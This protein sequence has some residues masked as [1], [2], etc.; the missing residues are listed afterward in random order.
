MLLP[1]D[2]PVYPVGR[3]GAMAGVGV[4]VGGTAQVS[5]YKVWP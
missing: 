4:G 1:H 3:L 5:G 2:G